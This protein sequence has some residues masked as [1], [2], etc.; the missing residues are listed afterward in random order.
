MESAAPRDLIIEL[1]H[2]NSPFYPKTMGFKTVSLQQN[3]RQIGG[4]FNGKKQ[5]RLMTSLILLWSLI[6]IW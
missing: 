5:T 3:L 1:Q 2:R 6:G 4:L